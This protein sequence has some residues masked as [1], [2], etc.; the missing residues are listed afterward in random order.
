MSSA[1]DFLTI[2]Q[3]N[4]NLRS[5]K[6]ILPETH[7]SRVLLAAKALLES[8]DLAQ[9][10]FGGH[11]TIVVESARQQ[12]LELDRYETRW[13]TMEDTA[14]DLNQLTYNYLISNTKSKTEPNTI[15]ANAGHALYQAGYLLRHGYANACVAGSLATT[16]EV[17]RACLKTVGLGR[18]ATCLSGAFILMRETQRTLLFADAA[19]VVEPDED[20][21]VS[22][23]CES[24]RTWNKVFP[25]IAPAVAFLSF[26]TKGSAHHPSNDKMATAAA[27]F[28]QAMP[29][30]LS[31]GEIQFDAAFD[32]EV[33]QKKAPGSPLPGKA[34][35]F[36]FP[37]LDAGNIAY[38]V[39]Q[40]LGHYQAFGPLVQ[41]S[42]KPYF[43]LSRGT[44]WQEIV[45]TSLLALQVGHDDDNS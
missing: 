7:D 39:C 41:G 32:L 12:G 1:N 4:T 5:K 30:V 21:L 31:D 18:G 35:I 2:L 25:E 13:T 10:V 40:R 37:N 15:A 44:T 27:H 16:A 8:T 33:G 29:E 11:R 3:K 45:T 22:I 19:I 24:V 14:D 34:N 20:Q 6:L 38:K 26:A 42:L 36:I 17:I 43:D 28:K 9:I 23:A